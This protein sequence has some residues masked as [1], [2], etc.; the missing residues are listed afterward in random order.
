MNENILIPKSEM[1]DTLVHSINSGKAIGYSEEFTFKKDKM[2]ID[3]LSFSPNEIV[4]DKMKRFEG[5]TNPAD[6]MIYYQLSTLS[7]KKG[8]F[9]S[10]Y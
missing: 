2:V 4:I 7:G 5:M 9:V 3:N 1:E 6:A 10:A 8:Y